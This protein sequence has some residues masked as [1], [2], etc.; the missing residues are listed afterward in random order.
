MSMWGGHLSDAEL[1]PHF[2]CHKRGSRRKGRGMHRAVAGDTQHR[3]RGCLDIPRPQQES[4][5][6]QLSFPGLQSCRIGMRLRC[7]STPAP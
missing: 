3:L 7:P 2:C 4:C 1:H 5:A 6:N